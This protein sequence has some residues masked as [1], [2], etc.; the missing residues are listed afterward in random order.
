MFKGTDHEDNWFFYHDALNL[1]T[2]K[3]TIAWMKEK[4]YLKHWLLPKLGLL[5]G[6]AYEHKLPGDSPELMPMDSTLNKDIDDSAK[7]HVAVTSHLVWNKQVKD[8]RK[9]SLATPKEGMFVCLKF[10]FNFKFWVRGEQF[11]MNIEKKEELNFSC[12][13]APPWITGQGTSALTKFE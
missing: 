10:Q 5:A 2:A 7:R 12:M 3:D 13:R 9:F 1:M 8:L 4:D 6:T 11:K